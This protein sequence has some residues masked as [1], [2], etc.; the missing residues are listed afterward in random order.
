[1]L[2]SSSCHRKLRLSP[3]VDNG[4]NT[5]MKFCFELNE[6]SWEADLSKPLPIF[7][8]L[9][10]GGLQPNHFGVPQAKQTTFE[11]GG[12]V[13]DTSRGGGCNVDILQMI[14]H[15]NGT[16]SETV[17]HIVDRA[18]DVARAGLQ[19]M[20]VAE[21]V[22]VQSQAASESKDT[23]RPELADDDHVISLAVL[24]TSLDKKD[25]R[26]VEALVIRTLPN[27]ERKKTLAYTEKD[28]FPFLSVQAIEKINELGVR[29]L[30]VDMPSIDRMHDDGLLTNHHL[31]WKVPEGTHELTK[32]THVG[33]TITEMIFVPD[34]IADG[35]YLLNL[36]IPPFCSDAAPS[37]PILFATKERQ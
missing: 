10:F 36:Q 16:H 11:G 8:D 20:F 26:G 5:F 4:S 19:S 30:L 17:G 24:E 25:F 21:V 29:H 27:L 12:F 1:M 2:A 32:T 34:S 6:K 13:G 9:D 35:R 15:C 33:K 37:R 7:I 22:S 31:F 28:P 23:Y 18:V 14:P 3:V